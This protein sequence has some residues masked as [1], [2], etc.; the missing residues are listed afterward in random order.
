MAKKRNITSIVIVKHLESA[1]NKLAD[2]YGLTRVVSTGVW[3][4]AK[5]SP[6]E[7]QNA[8]R[9]AM[10]PKD[11]TELATEYLQSLP[12]N[13]RRDICRAVLDQIDSEELS[14]ELGRKSAKPNVK[15]AQ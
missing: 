2:I 8:I 10:Q 15:S 11:N 3:L 9:E 4:L 14:E 6:E 1:K 7:Q 5:L 12:E 13:V